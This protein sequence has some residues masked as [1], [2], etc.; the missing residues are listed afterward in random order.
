VSIAD[1]VPVDEGNVEVQRSE[2]VLR[3]I[4]DN[5]RRRNALTWQMYDRLLDV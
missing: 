5:P 1:A 2:G 3:V 4:L